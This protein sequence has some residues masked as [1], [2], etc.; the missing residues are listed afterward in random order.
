MHATYN[1]HCDK[2]RKITLYHQEDLPFFGGGVEDDRMI[3]SLADVSNQPVSLLNS[4]SNALLYTTVAIGTVLITT[5]YITNSVNGIIEGQTHAQDQA[6]H[7]HYRSVHRGICAGLLGGAACGL[8]SG[9]ALRR[10]NNVYNV[11]GGPAPSPWHRVKISTLA[12]LA[13]G[14]I[15]GGFYASVLHNNAYETVAKLEIFS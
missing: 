10:L 6:Q 14:G 4:L 11:L 13:A 15:G 1:P 5:F 9:L 8:F 3:H 12:G 7:G 2:T